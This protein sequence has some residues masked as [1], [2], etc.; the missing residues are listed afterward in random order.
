[1][2]L[3]P[4]TH[5]RLPRPRPLPRPLPS[6]FVTAPSEPP[7]KLLEDPKGAPDAPK[8]KLLDAPKP[9]LL[10]AA[11]LEDPKGAPDAPKPKLLDAP[12]PKLLEDAP[13]PEPLEDPKAAGA[14]KDPI[15]PKAG[16]ADA[17]V[18]KEEDPVEIP[19]AP[20]DTDPKE[21]DPNPK[22]G[23]V[24]ND[25]LPLDEYV[26][27]FVSAADASSADGVV[28]KAGAALAPENESRDGA[29]AMFPSAGR[30]AAGLSAA[31]FASELEVTGPIEVA[32]TAIEVAEI[33]K[34]SRPPAGPIDAVTFKFDDDTS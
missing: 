4:R 9:K 25:E 13:N 10:E 29:A 20:D 6:L 2:V 11:P 17:A 14:P 27:V 5:Y 34:P 16:M 30:E 15:D 7:P 3:A 23:A 19:L 26:L 21:T 8:P 1:M 18:D 22:D 31:I 33:P 32:P 12:K 24:N 28:L